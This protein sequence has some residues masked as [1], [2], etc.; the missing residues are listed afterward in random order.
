MSLNIDR[1][2]RLINRA[3][4]ETVDEFVSEL[5]RQLEAVKWSWDGT[6]TVRRSG[7]VV[8]S[9]RDIIDTGALR[10][11]LNVIERD[12]KFYELIYDRIYAELVHEGY[13]TSTGRQK[14]PRPWVETAVSELDLKAVFI[15]KLRA[16]L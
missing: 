1:L 9:P 7:Q 12:P 8:G 14:P 11:S 6:I 16:L 4:K 3:F 13:R 15:S 10:N 5:S 2:E